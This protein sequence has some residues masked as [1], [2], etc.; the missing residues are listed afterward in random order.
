M[1]PPLQRI[2]KIL[3]RRG[4][5][6]RRA[7]E[8]C[9]RRGE[10]SV[11]GSVIQDVA[12]HISEDAKI[13]YKGRLVPL[14]EP[15]KIWRYHKP[16]GLMTTHTDPEGRLTVFKD[17]QERYPNLP[18]LISIGRLDMNSEGLLLLTNDGKIDQKLAHPSQKT[19][20]SYRIR[21]F[22]DVP[23]KRLAELEK[24]TCIDGIHYGPI[25]IEE[26]K[27]FPNYRSNQ[28]I[29]VSLW[30]G[31]NR[32]I[33]RVMEHYGLQ[34]SRLIR[35]S[36]GPYTLEGLNPHEVREEKGSLLSS[37]TALSKGFL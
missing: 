16:K 13:T 10:I 32:E 25:V 30:E 15:S 18:R 21:V 26:T 6:S 34:V 8:E 17:I 2:A 19:K 33:R 12:A 11:N 22:G 37:L 4:V 23:W 31:K 24:G 1:S 9:V 14:K 27:S 20:R 29:S 7:A 35:L 3:A 5:A 28:W 36:Y